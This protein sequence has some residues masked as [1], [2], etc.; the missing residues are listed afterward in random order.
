VPT[1]YGPQ[2]NDV[3]SQAVRLVMSAVWG[4]TCGSILLAIKDIIW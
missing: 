1:Y 3:P 4:F 2:E